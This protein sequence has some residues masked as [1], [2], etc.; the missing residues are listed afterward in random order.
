ML[1]RF[2][3]TAGGCVTPLCCTAAWSGT[4]SCFL[5]K[6]SG[7]LNVGD[8]QIQASENDFIK[9]IQVVHTFHWSTLT[10]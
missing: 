4:P 10:I 3:I 5:S 1:A 7:T 2:S 8:S 6:L 9:Y